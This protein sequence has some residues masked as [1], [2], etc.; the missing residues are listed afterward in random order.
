MGRFAAPAMV[1]AV[2]ARYVSSLHPMSPT[3]PSFPS[4]TH[5]PPNPSHHPPIPNTNKLTK[6]IRPVTTQKMTPADSYE[7]LV[8]QRKHRPVAPHLTIYQPQIP[9]ILSGLNRIT[10]VAV[11]GGFYIFGA[12]YLVSPLFGWHLDSASLAAGFAAWPV[13]AKV[14][15]KFAVALPFTFHSINGLRH[16]V[17]DM[18]LNFKNK[19]IALTGWAVVGLSFV[20]TLGL[21]AFV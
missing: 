5:P 6:P 19:N 4:N 21:V 10:G 18:A 9:W 20:S 7:I 17:W 11:S 13:L 16:L 8:A 15:A 1:S 12:A 14:A 2:Q 3:T